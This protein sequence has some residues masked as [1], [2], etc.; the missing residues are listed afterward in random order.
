MSNGLP[1]HVNKILEYLAMTAQ[2]YGNHLKWNEEAKLKA[3]LMNVKS[4]W[5]GVSVSAVRDRCRAL[6][7]RE[8]DITLIVD[9]VTRAQAGRRLVPQ[10]SYRDFQFEPS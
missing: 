7:M 4:R 10:R 1:Q 9:L 8:E 6:G 3:D 2:G 5:R